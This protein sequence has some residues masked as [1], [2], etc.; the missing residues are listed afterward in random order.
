MSLRRI[1]MVQ[2]RSIESCDPERIS[3]IDIGADNTVFVVFRQLAKHLIYLFD[4][5]VI[6][7]MKNMFRMNKNV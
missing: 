2:H 5:S 1:K 7:N 4:K 6:R 3:P